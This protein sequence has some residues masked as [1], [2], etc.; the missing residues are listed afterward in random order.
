MTSSC[1]II[2]TVRALDTMYRT[3]DSVIDLA[4]AIKIETA[5]DSYI[6]IAG[7]RLDDGGDGVEKAIRISSEIL[8]ASSEIAGPDGRLLRLRVGIHTGR[9]V[10]GNIGRMSTRFCIFGDAVNVASRMQ[11]AGKS[12]CVTM[13]DE[14]RSRAVEEGMSPDYTVDMGFHMIKGKG[15]MRI[16]ALKTGS[17]PTSRANAARWLATIVSDAIMRAAKMACVLCSG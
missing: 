9:L 8:K 6:A 14:T 12:N 5:G 2:D 15:L 16:W 3:I 4:G 11:S 17:W 10:A 13:S 1:Q 7:G